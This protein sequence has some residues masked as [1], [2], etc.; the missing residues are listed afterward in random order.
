MEDS[1]GRVKIDIEDGTIITT[2]DTTGQEIVGDTNQIVVDTTLDSTLQTEI[3][4][5][6]VIEQHDPM[7]QRALDTAFEIGPRDRH[8]IFS[9]PVRVTMDIDPDLE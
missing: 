8:M 9:Q 5:D 4:M 6:T 3:E 2:L 7:S 1:Q